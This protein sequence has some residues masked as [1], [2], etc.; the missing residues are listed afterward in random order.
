VAR[1]DQPGSAEATY[2]PTARR[3]A[4]ARRDGQVAHSAD[5]RGAIALAATGA[6]LALL[7][8]SI[9][10]QLV[11]TFAAGLR[12]APAREPMAA[13]AAR[14]LD[15]GARVLAAPLMVVVTFTLAAG[16]IQ[17]GGLW[18]GVPRADLGRLWPGWAGGRRGTAGSP[19]SSSSSFFLGPL[20]GLARAVVVL[21]VAATTLGGLAPLL[22]GLA[23]ASGARSLGAFGVAA[24][25]LGGRLALV[26][27]LLGA[28]DYAWVRARHRRA[29]RMT[30]RDLERERREQEGD[31][32]VRAERRR[33]RG[34]LSAGGA[35][36]GVG[37]ADLVVAGVGGDSDSADSVSGDRVA[38]ALV[39]ERGGPRAPVVVAV[40][41]RAAAGP[42]LAAARAA[43]VPVARDPDLAAVL[44][45]LDAGAEIPASTYERVAELLRGAIAIDAHGASR[46]DA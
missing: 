32:L 8:P 45:R 3:L 5:L 16:L 11:A 42:L 12:L 36:A 7:G 18:T 2:E 38:I 26:L 17:T 19:W 30:R 37:R 41:R 33:L 46:Q 4:D 15:S 35:I 40:A 44:E 9:V 1:G 20:A 31:A 27:L 6:A 43:G 24:R 22:I 23:G 28:L 13:A 25:A 34:E 14:A 39:Y 10:G 21:V 29:L